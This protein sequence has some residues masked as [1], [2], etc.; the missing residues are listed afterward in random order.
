MNS[1]GKA[2]VFL[3]TGDDAASIAAETAAIIAREAGPDPDPFRLD[4][5]REREGADRA[6][7]VRQAIRSLLSPPFLGGRKTV[8][9]K[10][11]SGFEDESGGAQPK[12]P[13]AV[14]LRELAVRIAAGV[15]GDIVLVLSGPGADPA[16]P[17]A[18]ACAA[19]GQVIACT[20][21]TLRDR[22]WRGVMRERIE[23]RAAEKGARLAREAIDYLVEALG[24]DTAAIPGEI[25]KLI[26]YVGGPEQPIRVQDAE[27][28]CC[29][30]GEEL[31]WALS[32]ALGARDAT[33]VL[34][35]V[36]VLL[37]QGGDEG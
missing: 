9:L 6:E 34:G 22:Q 16:K 26:C 27:A 15:P 17:L 36:S 20:R 32:N 30:R 19:N 37:A 12:G 14:A 3:I 13:E 35:A 33:A 5:F 8:W 29:G 18:Q 25:E 1:P 21:P 11:F 10:D 2:N 23:A 31:P 24:T 7:L 4:V 28:V